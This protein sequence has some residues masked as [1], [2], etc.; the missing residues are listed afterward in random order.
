MPSLLKPEIIRIDPLHPEPAL[1]A[2]A[3]AILRAGG[4]LAYP[5]E[6][7][8]GLAADADNATAVERLFAI[9]GRLADNPIALIAGSREE[10]I[11]RFAAS[12]SAPARRLMQAFWP[13]PL[14]LLFPAA[15]DVLP[16]LTAG[17]GMIGMRVSSHPVAAALAMALGRPITA[18]SA[19]FSGEKAC[20]TAAQVYESL[21]KKLDVIIDGGKAWG[22]QGSTM[23]DVTV[24]PPVIIREGAVPASRIYAALH[25]PT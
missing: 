9:K 2:A 20:L 8:Y 23:L 21:G 22:E 14:T 24:N 13:G 6:T 11:N 1:I 15:A 17:T 12:V 10:D 16:R 5:T 25:N 7:L 4:V 3:T 18:T 19:N